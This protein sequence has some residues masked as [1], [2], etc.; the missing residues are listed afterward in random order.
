MRMGVGVVMVDV[1]GVGSGE[2]KERVAVSSK[3]LWFKLMDVQHSSC[4][5][6]RVGCK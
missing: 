4:D 2:V 3:W 5:V 6:L 1:D